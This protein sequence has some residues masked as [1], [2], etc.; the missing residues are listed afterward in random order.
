MLRKRHNK[1]VEKAFVY[2]QSTVII[3]CDNCRSR[4][5]RWSFWANR[6]WFFGLG[7]AIPAVKTN[8][9]V[10]LGEITCKSGEI[11][12]HY[13]KS[14]DFVSPGG[15]G[16]ETGAKSGVSPQNLET[17][18]VC[19]DRRCYWIPQSWPW[20]LYTYPMSW[21]F[22]RPSSAH[23]DR[24]NY[25]IPQSWPWP[26]IYISHISTQWQALLPDT[27]VLT[28]TFTYLPH[29]M[30]FPSAVISTQWQALL[31]DT[32]V[33]TLTFTYLPHVMTFPSTVISTQWQA[34]LPDTTVLTL[35][36]IYLPHVMTF[37]SAVI[38]TQRQALLP[39]TTVLTL[40]FTYLPHVMTFPSA[41]ISTQ[42]QA[43]LPDTTVLTLTFIYL[44]HVMTFQHTVI[45]VTTGYQSWPWPLYTYPMSWLFPRPLSAHNDRRYYRIPQ[46]W[47][48]PL[49]CFPSDVAAISLVHRHSGLKCL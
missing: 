2:L 4:R 6:Y 17:W 23:N 30:T 31:P 47:P 14:G 43:L 33:L 40:T 8:S 46:S 27:T 29:V 25:W 48:W 19:S 18:N 36:F 45:G 28:L 15:G 12:R 16:G 38:S 5:R 44:P 20:P 10:L 26:F 9:F 42:W 11:Q 32:T 49:S 41:I 13:K 21:L 22:P 7:Q 35:T 24:R 1:N 34:L 37:P 3:V 39:D